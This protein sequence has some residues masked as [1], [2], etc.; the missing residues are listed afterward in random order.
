MIDTKQE[1][2][3][4]NS[5]FAKMN[6]RAQDLFLQGLRDIQGTALDRPDTGHLIAVVIIDDDGVDAR[7]IR[8]PE[9]VLKARR[10]GMSADMIDAITSP[11]AAGTLDVLLLLVEN[12]QERQIVFCLPIETAFVSVPRAG[13]E[14]N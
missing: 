5:F 14:N 10:A 6:A 13:S 1:L 12:N 4:N 11:P 7:L 9:A 3:E 8:K 2:I